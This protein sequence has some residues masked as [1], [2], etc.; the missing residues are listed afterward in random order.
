MTKNIQW[1]GISISEQDSELA[2]R[3]IKQDG[4]LR[5]IDQKNLLLIAAAL[6]V[7]NK[8]PEVITSPGKRKDVTHQSLINGESYSEYRQYISLIFFQTV[9]KRDLKSMAD[10]KIMVDNFVDYA[11]R[12]LHLLKAEYLESNDSDQKLLQD[13][14][15]LL[16]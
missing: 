12:G 3:I 15:G 9:G 6:A 13:F 2:L 4:L 8:A 16:K 1:P 11:R 7:K 14:V 10:P 5:N